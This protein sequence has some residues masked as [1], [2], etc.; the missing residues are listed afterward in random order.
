MKKAGTFF[1][2]AKKAVTRKAKHG[3]APPFLKI[4]Y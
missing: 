3:N 4:A 2:P 1:I